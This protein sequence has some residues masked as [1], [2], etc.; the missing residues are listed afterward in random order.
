MDIKRRPCN[1]AVPY[2]NC[3]STAMNELISVIAS[4]DIIRNST[5]IKVTDTGSC[6]EVSFEHI[7]V[8]RRDSRYG[9]QYAHSYTDYCSNGLMFNYD[10]G[11]FYMAPGKTLSFVPVFNASKLIVSVFNKVTSSQARHDVFY[12]ID[13]DTFLQTLKLEGGNPDI[14][15]KLVDNPPVIQAE[16]TLIATLLRARKNNLAKGTV[17]PITKGNYLEFEKLLSVTMLTFVEKLSKAFS[18]MSPSFSTNESTLFTGMITTSKQVA[19]VV[20]TPEWE[21]IFKRASDVGLT[22]DLGVNPLFSSTARA[23]LARVINLS[24]RNGIN[25]KELGAY[26]KAMKLLN[27]QDMVPD[28]FSDNI[29]SSV[30]SLTVNIDDYDL[31]SYTDKLRDRDNKLLTRAKQV[32]DGFKS[33]SGLQV[34]GLDDFNKA[35]DSIQEDDEEAV[36]LSLLNITDKMLMSLTNVIRRM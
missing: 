5:P 3:N 24:N 13:I 23:N 6:F 4:N 32:A 20:S 21:K 2:D 1:L 31:D 30:T 35:I 10:T 15:N 36:N 7:T 27:L 22:S 19:R 12:P 26:S 14:L 33:L 29:L 16:S 11:M 17:N 25:N 28:K 8:E 34:S 18:S 9:D